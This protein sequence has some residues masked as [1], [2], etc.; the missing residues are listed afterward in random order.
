M[1]LHDG[2]VSTTTDVWRMLVASRDGD[3]GAVRET[4]SGYP[5][6][7]TGTYNY[8]PRAGCLQVGP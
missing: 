4:A 1:S 6:L 5:A 7:I 8:T 2:V 3:L